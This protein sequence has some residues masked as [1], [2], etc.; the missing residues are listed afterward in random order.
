M[1]ATR[2]A[3][4][5]SAEYFC[6]CEIASSVNTLRELL[7]EAA[8]KLGLTYVACGAHVDPQHLPDGAFL[9]HNYPAE[10]VQRF[11]A[12]AYHRIDPVLR[13][14]EAVTDSFW[15]HE[16]A[17]LAPLSVR[18][19]RLLNEARAFRIADGYTIPLKHDFYWSASISVMSESGDIDEWT[20][21][22]VSMIGSWIYQRSSLLLHQPALVCPRG[23]LTKRERE[24]LSL[25][26]H[27]AGD[28]EISD[29]LDISVSTVCRHLDQAKIRLGAR[30]R[31]HAVYRGVETRQITR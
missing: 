22:A 15:W 31:E 14:A 4:E 25:K 18:Q 30:S 21:L 29:R 27:G 6:R 17:F 16:A 20:R 8:E 24:C 13:H 10:W 28:D 3:A 9:F 5:F 12:R 23:A 2:R 19:K 1:G 26:A 7:F 11:C